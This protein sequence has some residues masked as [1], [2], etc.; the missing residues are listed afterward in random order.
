MLR[1]PIGSRVCREGNFLV[2]GERGDGDEQVG[3]VRGEGC[4]DERHARVLSDG[5]ELVG[6][7]VDEHPAAVEGEAV[8]V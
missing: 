3:G 8:L 2:L 5:E 6:F 4:C 7:C 1:E